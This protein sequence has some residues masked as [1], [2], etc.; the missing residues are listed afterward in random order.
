MAIDDHALEG[1]IEDSK[2]LQSD[3]MSSTRASLAEMVDLGHDRRA[4]G[5]LDP[6]EGAQAAGISREV[7]VKALVAGGALATAA[8]GPILLGFAASPAFAAAATDIQMLQTAAS[9]E[10]LA[11]NTYRA[12]LTLPYI[13]GGA[14]NPTI[15]AFA[16]ETMSQ[17]AQHLQAFNAAATALGG[18]PQT[19]PDPKFVPTVQA[20]IAAIGG[21]SASD[22]ALSVVGLAITLENVAAETYVSNC[23]KFATTNAKKVTASIMGVEAQHVA[24]LL[25]VQ[26]LLKA[27]AANL[28]QLSPTVAA[29]LPAAA[30]S[31]GFP[32]GFYSTTHASPA[33]EGAVS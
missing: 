2:D 3:A 4:R 26:A 18:K 22:G 1:L 27:G 13:G 21:Q 9:I 30:G 20:A 32:N 24:T 28:I 31:V 29:Q 17:H 5:E 15:K 6:A 33:T 19:A 7:F 16:T 10:A 14:A 11:V 12:A 23:S 25:A 8:F